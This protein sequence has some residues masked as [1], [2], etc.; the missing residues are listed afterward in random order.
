[1][2]QTKPQEGFPV[3]PNVKL[4]GRHSGKS[5]ERKRRPGG[6]GSESAKVVWNQGGAGIDGESIGDF[7]ANLEN[8]LYKILV[9][10]RRHTRHRADFTI[11]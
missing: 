4:R 9:C 7:E 3:A 1:M 5:G 11:G 8:N 10:N 2:K 6:S